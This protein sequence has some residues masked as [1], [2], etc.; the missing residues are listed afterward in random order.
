M[1]NWGSNNILLLRGETNLSE[2][3]D[4][5]RTSSRLNHCGHERPSSAGVKHDGN[6][7]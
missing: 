1:K 7:A 6:E 4:T 5:R 2:S 3:I